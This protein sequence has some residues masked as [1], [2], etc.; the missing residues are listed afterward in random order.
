MQIFPIDDTWSTH[1]WVAMV[2]LTYDRM[3]LYSMQKDELMR[4][5]LDDYALIQ[6]AGDRCYGEDHTVSLLMFIMIL[7]RCLVSVINVM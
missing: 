1:I 5:Y 2:F 4:T 3:N 7:F 6:V